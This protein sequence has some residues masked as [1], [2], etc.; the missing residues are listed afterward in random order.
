MERFKNGIHGRSVKT[1]VMLIGYVQTDDFMTWRTRINSWIVELSNEPA[2]N[3][4]WSRDE[5]LSTLHIDKNS[6][7]LCDST[8]FRAGD[9]LRVVHLWVYLVYASE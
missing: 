4:P 7:A 1:S 6:V 2:H 3:P 9:S 5:Q 8:L